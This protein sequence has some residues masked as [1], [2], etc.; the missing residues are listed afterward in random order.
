VNKPGATAPLDLCAVDAGQTDIRYAVY[1]EGRA[2]L[3]G[4]T[5]EGITNLL[6]AGAAEAFEA[7][8][9]RIR[10]DC[11]AALG[12]S[13][14]RVVSAGLTGVAPEREEY[15]VARELFAACFP[16]ASL[17]LN[18]D[19]VTTHAAH[20]ADRAGVILHAGSGDFA[21]GR[22]LNGRQMRTGGW[23]YLLGD[24]GAGFGLG[25]AGI[26]AALRAAEGTGED[27]SLQEELLAFFVIPRLDQLKSVVYSA[28]FE[29]RRVADFSRRV[30]EHSGRGDP[31]AR[32][33]LEAGALSM[34]RLVPPVV[35]SLE[36]KQPEV[37]LTGA[38][39]LH[40][41]EYAERC[42]GLLL[43]LLGGQARVGVGEK[44]GLGGA[45]WLGLRALESLDPAGGREAESRP[46]A[47]AEGRKSR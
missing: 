41:A 18:S 10:R 25:L 32:G 11:A 16:G 2:V 34:A 22:D 26:R 1:R 6:L 23:G 14:F 19:M 30:F 5:G 17:V 33:I 4:A 29:R 39:F 31:V 35:R 24:E 36:L 20:F 27:T 44:S 28:S 3:Q 15:Q 7:S 21:Y 9:A 47:A 8:L 42:G 40:Q 45:I 37:V 43:E 12:C 38:L 46:A 13:S